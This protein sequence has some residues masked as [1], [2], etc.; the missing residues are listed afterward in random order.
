[1]I[2]TWSYV[3]GRLNMIVRLSVVLRIG[4][5]MT[6]IDVSTNCA[7]I[8]ISVKVKSVSLVNSVGILFF[9]LLVN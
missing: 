9:H 1:M 3:K 5:L 6:V 2:L 4:L 8:I 7:E